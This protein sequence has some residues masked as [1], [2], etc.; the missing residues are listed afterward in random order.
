MGKT[1][2]VA[3]VLVACLV[4]VLILIP[5][6]GVGLL[7]VFSIGREFTG[8]MPPTYAAS[9]YDPRLTREATTAKVVIS[10]LNRYHRVH[11]GFPDAASQ[12]APYLPP[13]SATP[14]A[15]KHGFVCGWSYLRTDDG[16][17]YHLWRKLGWD[18]ALEYE[19]HGS[20][21]RWV[22]EPGDGSAD[23]EITLKP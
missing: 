22:F 6:T 19:F 1:Y 9:S 3:W 15:L 10:A 11:S 18:P 5:L 16:K 14:I 8:G 7:Q 23:K 20:K 17:G 4:A 12:L 2:R 13:M 21:G